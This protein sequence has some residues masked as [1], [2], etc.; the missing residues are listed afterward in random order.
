M[1]E[2]NDQVVAIALTNAL[3]AVEN[4]NGVALAAVTELAQSYMQLRGTQDR[5]GI[6]PDRC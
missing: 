2:F 3:A 5:L 6:A 1:S 4:R